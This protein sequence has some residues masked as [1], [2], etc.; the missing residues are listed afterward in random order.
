MRL[1]SIV[2]L[3]FALILPGCLFEETTVYVPSSP[4]VPKVVIRNLTPE[5]DISSAEVIPG[6]PVLARLVKGSTTFVNA[7][8]DFYDQDFFHFGPFQASG[9][10]IGFISDAQGEWTVEGYVPGVLG[11]GNFYELPIKPSHSQTI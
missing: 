10:E 9:T 5:I 2:G 3:L 11:S 4:S 1:V 8:F 7:S 6:S